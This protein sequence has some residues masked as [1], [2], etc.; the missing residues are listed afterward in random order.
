MLRVGYGNGA[1]AAAIYLGRNYSDKTLQELGELACVQYSAVTMAIRRIAK[2]LKSNRLLA[3]K[4]KRL[5]S[6]LLVLVC[7]D[8]TPIFLP[9]I[10]RALR[11]ELAF[12]KVERLGTK[13]SSA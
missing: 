13:L 2:R 3:K 4:I 10:P 5:E 6:M 12:A 7:L 11:L 9:R 8:A 1:L